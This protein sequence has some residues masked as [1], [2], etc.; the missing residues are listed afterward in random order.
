[1][2]LTSGKGAIVEEWDLMDNKKAEPDEL[3]LYGDFLLC[4]ALRLVLWS[5]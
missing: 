2:T 1:M 4:P 5:N 3:P